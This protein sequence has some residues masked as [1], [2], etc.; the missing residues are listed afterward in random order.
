MIWPVQ[1]LSVDCLLGS[2]NFEGSVERIAKDAKSLHIHA[3]TPVN[4]DD[5]SRLSYLLHQLTILL[6]L[7]KL[8]LWRMPVFDATAWRYPFSTS[9]SKIRNRK[10]LGPSPERCNGFEY[11]TD[12]IAVNRRWKR[13]SAHPDWSLRLP[14]ERCQGLKLRDRGKVFKILPNRVILLHGSL[15]CATVDHDE[16]SCG[17][18]DDFDVLEDAAIL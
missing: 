4:I 3:N 1:G 15:L 10:G 7:G 14:I 9:I 18:P 16:R 8:R 6:S 2:H 13:R 17:R 12:K 11:A 5:R